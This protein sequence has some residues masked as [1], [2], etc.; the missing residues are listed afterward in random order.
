[1]KL[2]KIIK[3]TKTAKTPKIIEIPIGKIDG[4][5]W[6]WPNGL[7]THLT[8]MIEQIKKSGTVPRGFAA[9]CEKSKDTNLQRLPYI[10]KAHGVKSQQ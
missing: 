7:K 6:V 5:Y 3:K 9:A 1:M 8:F 2:P 10:I 4:H